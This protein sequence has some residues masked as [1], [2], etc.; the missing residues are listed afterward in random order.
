M[1]KRTPS[2]EELFALV[3]ERPAREVWLKEGLPIA[4]SDR[5]AR[6]SVRSLVG[7][8]LPVAR[9]QVVV[10]ERC[11]EEGEK[12]RYGPR[13]F[14]RMSAVLQ[15]RIARN[16]QLSCEERL[17]QVCWDLGWWDS[18]FEVDSVGWPPQSDRHRYEFCVSRN[19]AW[20]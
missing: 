11:D 8:L 2:R 4:M 7:K 1:R 14:V 12:E 19:E 6:Q 15:Q 18:A 5:G 9:E 13:L 16:V 17:S 20:L 10:F 3:W